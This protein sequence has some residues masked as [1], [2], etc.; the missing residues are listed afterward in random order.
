MNQRTP[1]SEPAG[2]FDY[3]QGG[4]HYSKIRRPE[5]SFERAIRVALGS[6]KT[7]INVGAGTGSYEPTDLSV[8][9][10][11]PSAS[12]RMQRPSHLTP[13]VDAT[14]ED[15]PFEDNAFDAAMA[16]VTIHQWRDLERGLL[17]MRRVTRGPIVIMTFDPEVLLTFWLSEFAPKLMTYEAGRMPAINTVV[18]LLQQQTIVDELPIPFECADGFGE[19]FFGRPEAFLDE[20]VR[21][22]QSAW[23][24][25]SNE[26]ERAS[27]SALRTSLEDGSWDET[28]G[29]LRTASHYCGAVRLITSLPSN[30]Q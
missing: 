18:N 1:R 20:R 9:A 27:I 16:T 5:P 7:V 2:D 10:V 30:D 12:M 26:E 25:I 29:Y 28:F 3:E 8:T 17:E 24:F 19:A 11:E 14:A 13:A 22:S 21:R 23:G 4:Q 15:L 6:A